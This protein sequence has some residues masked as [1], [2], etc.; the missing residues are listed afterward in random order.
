MAIHSFLEE[1]DFSGKTIVPFVTH[2]TG[3][4]AGTIE[5]IKEN[6]PDS[7]TVI[8]PIGIYR[9]DVDKSQPGVNEWLDR[10]GFSEAKSDTSVE[11]EIAESDESFQK[12]VTMT[13]DG[14]KIKAVLYDTPAANKLYEMLPLELKFEDYNSVEKIAFLPETLPTGEEENSFD[15]DIGDVC[16]YAPWGNHSIFYKDFLLSRGLISLGHIESGM[17]IFSGMDRDFT[18]MIEKE[19]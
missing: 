17:E 7:A 19:D 13:V 10:I 8:E 5:G 16:L 1:Y 4:L 11:T 9:S 12:H 14:Q 6:L 18:V 2:G 15:P 3:G